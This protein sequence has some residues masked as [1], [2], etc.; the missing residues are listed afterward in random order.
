MLAKCSYILDGDNE[1]KL[2]K[3]DFEIIRK[4]NISMAENALRILGVAYK[5]L[6][7]ETTFAEEDLVFV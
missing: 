3:K 7:K 4:A 5:K 1:R 6:D 2:T